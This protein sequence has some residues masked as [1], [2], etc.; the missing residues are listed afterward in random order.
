MHTMSDVKT[1]LGDINRKYGDGAILYMDSEPIA[2]PVIPTGIEPFDQEV[3]LIGGVPVGRVTEITGAPAMGKS[4]LACHLIAQAQKS[5]GAAALVDLQ[6]SFDPDYATAIGVDVGRMLIAQPD[7][8]ESALEI[9]ESLARS[10]AVSVIVLDHAGALMPRE[11]CADDPWPRYDARTAA[12]LQAR[13]LS[14][15]LR[16]ITA[17]AARTR[18][19]VVFLNQTDSRGYS[20]AG[21]ALKFYASVR[22]SLF[23]ASKDRVWVKVVKNKLAPP[24]KSV[25][26]KFTDAG[27]VPCDDQS[28][29]VPE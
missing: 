27:M 10:G 15:A 21:N 13:L 11:L 7:D 28:A 23:R 5:E 12:G 17:I 14:Q 16:R 24:F 8:G 25:K 22:I 29:E 18:C 9:M 1:V 19:A 3:I 4:T 6:H 20:Q 26:V 2:V